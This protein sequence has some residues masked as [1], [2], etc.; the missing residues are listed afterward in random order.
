MPLWIIYHSPSTFA[1]PQTKQALAASITAI[2]LAAGLPAFY[3]NVLFQPVEPTSFYVGGVA[4]PAMGVEDADADGEKE[5]RERPFVRITI[6]HLARQLPNDTVR[7]NFLNKV[8]AVLKPYIADR[9]YDWEYTVEEL[10]R[11]LW[12]VQGMV[13]PMPGTEAEKEW[14]RLGK[15][16]EFESEKGVSNL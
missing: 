5:S 6:Q 15:A 3:V 10:R 11:D 1:S 4:R 7:D 8:D 12:K 14:V 2:Y 16:V 13:P 9:G